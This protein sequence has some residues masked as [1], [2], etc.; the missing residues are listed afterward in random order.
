MILRSHIGAGF[1]LVS[2]PL[3]EDL[4]DSLAARAIFLGIF[5]FLIVSRDTFSLQ[6]YTPRFEGSEL[7]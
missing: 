2:F 4:Y 3:Y 5:W 6:Q 7:S 1:S